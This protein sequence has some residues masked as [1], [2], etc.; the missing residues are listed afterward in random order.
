MKTMEK[1]AADWNIP[2]AALADLCERLGAASEPEFKYAK[3][4]TTEAGVQQRERLLA[5]QTGG[6]LWRN[7]TGVLKNEAGIPI[8][9]GLCNDSPKVN[10]QM[11]S[12]DL[13]G[14]M[15]I[16]ITKA[17]VGNYVGQFVARE[18]KAPGWTYKDTDRERAQLKFITLINTLGGDGRFVS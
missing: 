8:R 9:F 11:K 13:I 15:P 7:N 12:S 18:V 2:Q 3:D 5:S 6:R 17:M 1:W 14:I 10:Q 16:L 4:A